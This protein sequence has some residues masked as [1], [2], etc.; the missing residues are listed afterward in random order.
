MD[1]NEAAKHLN[2]RLCNAPWLT[3]IGVGKHQEDTCLFLYVNA[4]RSNEIEFLDSGWEGYVVVVKKMGS[5]RPLRV[6][7]PS[8]TNCS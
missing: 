3:A 7:T 4:L 8:V 1:A 6:F 2:Q 5:P